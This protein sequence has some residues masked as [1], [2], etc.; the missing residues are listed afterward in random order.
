MHDSLYRN[1][2]F[3][4]LSS[5]SN[6]GL[7]FIFWAICTRVYSQQQVGLGTTLIAVVG[8]ASGIGLLGYNNSI[9]RFL[10]RVADKN[11][12]L[13]TALTSVAIVSAIA[14]ILFM[15]LGKNNQAIA[16]AHKNWAYIIIFLVTVIVTAL[17]SIIDNIFTAYKSSYYTFVKNILFNVIKI[18][19]I[20]PFLL[21]GGFGIFASFGVAY[22]V[23]IFGSIAILIKKFHF[24]PNLSI[25]IN[26]IKKTSRFS[27]ANYAV[28]YINALP[29]F[30]V[31]III[32]GTLGAENNAA[33]Y[34]ALTVASILYFIPLGISNSLFAEGSHNENDL[35]RSIVK[36]TRIIG[37][38]II[39]AIIVTIIAAPW[40]LSIFGAS[41]VNQATGVLRV[42]ALT[43][44][45]IAIC[46]LCG[47]ILNIMHKLKYLVIAN[48]IGAIFVVGLIYSISIRESATIFAISWGWFFGW[49]IY[50]LVYLFA[51]WRT[52]AKASSTTA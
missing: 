49:L 51:V 2:I 15:L 24:Q 33:F 32:T 38:L 29:T 22:L 11:K 9:I 5:L 23:V 3:L 18:V 13:N 27:L 12:L 44:I 20:Y 25:D 28:S 34:M 48:A 41:Y 43:A 35:R 6:A 46:Y 47:T 19:L 40:L 50:A 1:S 14:A 45:F 10:P 37:G 30:A 7:G 16:L 4:L 39:P 21:L 17:S 52:F 42:L 8:L 36:A 26:T 31:P